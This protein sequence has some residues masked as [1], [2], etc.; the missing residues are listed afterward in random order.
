VLVACSP[1]EPP[2]T[3]V[4]E[5][6][7]ERSLCGW[8]ELSGSPDLDLNDEDAIGSAIG[9]VVVLR[10]ALDTLFA[11]I[12]GALQTGDD[13]LVRLKIVV[14]NRWLLPVTYRHRLPV[15]PPPPDQQVSRVVGHRKI[16]RNKTAPAVRF[17]DMRLHGQ[18]LSL[19]V[20]NESPAGKKLLVHKLASELR[21]TKPPVG[22]FALT[23]TDVTPWRHLQTALVAAACYNRGPGDEP[24]EVILD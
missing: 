4:Q 24:N 23:A 6:P 10:A 18:L 11:D 19:Y 5:V 15:A 20:E 22:A 1:A 13:V 14:D 17:A 21:N 7:G 9:Q 12:E 16:T 3:A 2:S 8:E